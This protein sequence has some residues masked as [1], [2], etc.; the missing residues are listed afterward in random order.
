MLL[1]GTAVVPIEEVQVGTGV[2]FAGCGVYASKR[3]VAVV[4]CRPEETRTLDCD[5]EAVLLDEL[6]DGVPGLAA[7]LAECRER[8]S[9]SRLAQTP[10]ASWTPR[11]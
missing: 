8:L 1:P 6:I 9:T 2:L 7:V 3:P 5:G 11:M 4:V 10:S